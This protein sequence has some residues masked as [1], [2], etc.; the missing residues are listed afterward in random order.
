M[1]MSAGRE[2]GFEPGR[3]APVELG[4][5]RGSGSGETPQREGEVL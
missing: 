4:G 3:H 5:E 2:R 1:R